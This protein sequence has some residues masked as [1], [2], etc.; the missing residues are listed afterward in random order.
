MDRALIAVDKLDEWYQSQDKDSIK[1]YIKSNGDLNKGLIARDAGFG[2]KAL[3]DTVNGNPRLQARYDEIVDEMQIEKWLFLECND[4]TSIENTNDITSDAIQKELDK[5]KRQVA[6]LEAKLA[7]AN[8][9][10]A[11]T[12]SHFSQLS[13]MREVLTELGFPTR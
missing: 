2:R 7:K 5:T 4:S 10:I 8:A 13:E 1:S 9:M 6:D 12:E 11:Q 3:T